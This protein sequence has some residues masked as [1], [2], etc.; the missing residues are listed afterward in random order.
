MQIIGGGAAFSLTL[1]D[2]RFLGAVGGKARASKSVR[3]PYLQKEERWVGTAE[4]SEDTHLAQMDAV[5]GPPLWTPGSH[6]LTGFDSV[7]SK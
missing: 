7:S 2:P 6:W 1:V 5:P 4:P 3:R